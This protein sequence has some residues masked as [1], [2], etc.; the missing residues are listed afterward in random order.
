MHCVT[1]QFV[2]LFAMILV[3][4]KPEKITVLLYLTVVDYFFSVRLQKQRETQF[5]S[6]TLTFHSV[7]WSLIR[8]QRLPIVK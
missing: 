3:F 8:K 6:F 1:I 4:G 2:H 7:M 5:A